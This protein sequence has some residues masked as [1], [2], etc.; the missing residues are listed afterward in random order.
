MRLKEIL[1]SKYE[2]KIFD[3]VYENAPVK[4]IDFEKRYGFNKYVYEILKKMVKKG[5]LIKTPN[6]YDLNEKFKLPLWDQHFFFEKIKEK[7]EGI[8]YGDLGEL[9]S[10]GLV[11]Y[12]HNN[13]SV[14]GFPI[15]KKLSEYQFQI[16]TTILKRIDDAFDDLKDLKQIYE[17]S[18]EYKQKE[19]IMSKLALRY[20]LYHF[21]LSLEEILEQDSYNEKS[22]RFVIDLVKEACKL[23]RKHKLK[24]CDKDSPYPEKSFWRYF[25]N[26]AL[27]MNDINDERT[28]H[29]LTDFRDEIDFLSKEGKWFFQTNKKYVCYEKELNDYW[30]MESYKNSKKEG[31]ILTENKER[32]NLAILSTPSIEQ[33][34]ELMNIKT[35]LEYRVNGVYNS[36]LIKPKNKASKIENMITIYSLILPALTPK[37]FRNAVEEREFKNSQIL[38]KWFSKREINFMIGLIKN[39]GNQFPGF[40][41]LEKIIWSEAFSPEP[42]GIK[43]YRLW[44]K[45]EWERKIRREY[46]YFKNKK[47]ISY[48]EIL[49]KVKKTF[50]GEDIEDIE[51]IATY[52]FYTLE[53]EMDK[54]N[55]TDI[56][57]D[58]DKV[59]IEKE[60]LK[61]EKE[62]KKDKK[63]RS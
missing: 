19:V 61:L 54:K 9:K 24:L 36:L 28:L 4:P 55:F 45:K 51:G 12:F 39:Y 56:K 18:K 40:Y 20:L 62:L 53:K 35:C 1:N 49:S 22:Y 16:F 7:E 43:K 17:I 57:V 10:M 25:I 31:K 50:E 29:T 8:L 26:P 3:I 48:E 32:E 47:D 6:G 59:D 23:G 52:L 63:N 46:N 30:I 5:I 33:M 38:K 41:P 21:I 60:L 27:L 14:Y 13:H 2:K 15:W 34:K 42:F 11:R 44:F 58:I 37:G